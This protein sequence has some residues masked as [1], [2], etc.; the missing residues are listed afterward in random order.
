MSHIHPFPTSN[1]A[2]NAGAS[3]SRRS[4]P[5]YGSRCFH[6]AHGP[7][8]CRGDQ[9]QRTRKQ[10]RQ[11]HLTTVSPLDLLRLVSATQPRPAKGDL[12]PSRGLACLRL[13]LHG[14]LCLDVALDLFSN[15]AVLCHGPHLD[16]S[17]VG[18]S[19]AFLGDS[20]CFV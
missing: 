9:R 17:T 7:R 13:S 10:P 20:H 18:Q 16:L 4:L 8:L 14:K 15:R 6:V 3:S 5:L 11:R 12:R 19:R 1:G 2:T